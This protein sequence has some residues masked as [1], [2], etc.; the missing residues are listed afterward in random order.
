VSHAIDPPLPQKLAFLHRSE[1]LTTEGIPM[2]PGGERSFQSVKLQWPGRAAVC[3]YSPRDMAAL[4]ALNPII[5]ITVLETSTCAIVNSQNQ[6]TKKD[7]RRLS[8][9]QPFARA[10]PKMAHAGMHAK[11][12]AGILDAL[13]A[14]K[15]CLEK[16][17]NLLGLRGSNGIL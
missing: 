8:P 10:S 3:S 14:L 1:G 12:K 6:R 4:V 17:E 16:P 7:C 13:S 5:T 9:W 15:V 11:P 2:E